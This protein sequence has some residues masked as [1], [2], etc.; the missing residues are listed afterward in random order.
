MP[1]D[2]H[3]WFDYDKLNEGIEKAYGQNIKSNYRL[4]LVSLLNPEV[5][6]EHKNLQRLHAIFGGDSSTSA[7][8]I[9]LQSQKN[10]QNN[11]RFYWYLAYLTP[12][13]PLE[14]GVNNS[15]SWEELQR[16]YGAT[17]SA[18]LASKFSNQSLHGKLI[19]FDATVTYINSLLTSPGLLQNVIYVHSRWGKVRCATVIAGYLMKYHGYTAQDAFDEAVEN[20]VVVDNPV[21]IKVYLL[22]YQAFLDQ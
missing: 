20:T 4:Y 10:H 14:P 22:H 9:S 12:H 16:I 2:G 15:T 3:G 13:F 8:D 21:E 11:S 7:Y 6:E 17:S 19:N 5:R 18:T 1:I